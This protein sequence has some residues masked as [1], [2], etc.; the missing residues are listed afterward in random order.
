MQQQIFT[1]CY[2]AHT[3]EKFIGGMEWKFTTHSALT[4]NNEIWN[5]LVSIGTGPTKKGSQ[6]DAAVDMLNN[7]IDR[8]P[9]EQREILVQQQMASSRQQDVGI[10]LP[11]KPQEAGMGA[12]SKFEEDLAS[13][14]VVAEEEPAASTIS[15]S[16]VEAELK[17]I[18]DQVINRV[19]TDTRGYICVNLPSVADDRTMNLLAILIGE[20]DL[21][22]HRK[23]LGEAVAKFGY[24][25]K[26]TSHSQ[27]QWVDWKRVIRASASVYN[28]KTI[29]SF[30][31]NNY[32][33]VCQHEV[34]LEKEY[35][36]INETLRSALFKLINQIDGTRHF[37]FLLSSTYASE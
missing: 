11:F 4:V 17:I 31:V 24:R 30:I 26:V 23:T 37:Q 7:I 10:P 8:I 27:Q 21:L 14:I 9:E 15:K 19:I 12:R 36:L 20:R 29:E 33:V 25:F 5:H 18:E 1:F 34:F 35:E 28:E 32:G 2:E 16:S 13:G 6:E 3:D 22:R